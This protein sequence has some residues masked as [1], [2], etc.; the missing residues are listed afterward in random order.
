MAE[1]FTNSLGQQELLKLA[2]GLAPSDEE[3][4]MQ[5]G[6]LQQALWIERSTHGDR[7]LGPLEAANAY[8]GRARE[9]RPDSISLLVSSSNAALQLGF[10]QLSSGGN[11][12]KE[13]ARAARNIANAV[14]E[15]PD[16]SQN[17]KTNFAG[18][19][20]HLWWVASE[21]AVR[22]G[23]DPSVSLMEA[24]KARREFGRPE[25]HFGFSLMLEAMHLEAKGLDPLRS[26]EEA[27]SHLENLFSTQP[28]QKNNFFARMVLGEIHLLRAEFL[29]RKHQNPSPWIERALG[30][31]KVAVEKDPAAAYPY[32]RLPRAHALEARIAIQAKQDASPSVKAALAAAARG[33]AI[34]PRNAQIQQ[35]AADA[36][37]ADGQAR[38]AAGRDPGPALEAARRALEAADAV[39]PRDFRSY[40]LRAEVAKEAA[41]FVRA[42]GGDPARELE[43][44]E[45][46]CRKGLGIKGD[47]RRFRML[48]AEA[49]AF[50][51]APSSVV[52]E[53]AKAGSLVG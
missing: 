26:F 8:F 40:L 47:E 1:V 42:G 24:A 36:H 45:Q 49:Q 17:E 19:R 53:A 4:F 14:E 12:V 35:A 16:L 9:I 50:R 2:N 15:R 34:N 13:V 30:E 37:L 18:L 43:R 10:V 48:L 52:T 25:V 20:H 27:G 33:L 23:R 41:A 39:N 44:L 28:E 51:K 5:L 21:A 31:L 3:I 7:G 29:H 38:A 11:P 32:Y 6:W 22:F 46:A